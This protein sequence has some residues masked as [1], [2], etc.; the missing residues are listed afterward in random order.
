MVVLTNAEWSEPSRVATAI[1]GQYEPELAPRPEPVIADPDP[2]VTAEL[3]RLLQGL[4]RGELDLARL[5]TDEREEWSAEA[6][7]DAAGLLNRLGGTPRLELLEKNTFGE[8]TR[9]V[10]RVRLDRGI[11]RLVVVND[12]AGLLTQLDIREAILEQ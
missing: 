5:A 6:V 4:S 1:A 11:A 9:R 3:Q 7:N 8:V 2:A 10:Y 12:K